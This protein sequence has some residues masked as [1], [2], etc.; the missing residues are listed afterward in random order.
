MELARFATFHRIRFA[1]MTDAEMLDLMGRPQDALAWRIGTAGPVGPDGVRL[2]GNVWCGLALFP[3]IHSARAVFQSPGEFLPFV[4]DAAESWH[5]L[6]QPFMHRGECN[7]LDRN[8][9]G[10]FFD[11]S[12]GDPG[13]PCLVLTSAGFVAGPNLVME[14]VLSFRRAVD[15]AKEWMDAQPGILAAEVFTPYTR[16]EDGFTVSLWK[17]DESMLAAAYRPGHHRSEIDRHK[18]ECVMDRSSFTRSRVMDARG[19]WNGS[20][21]LQAWSS[22]S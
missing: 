22:A 11:A 8:N 20:D 2:P 19:R 13:G 9:P 15:R 10:L 6:I 5:A 1:G 3:D 14:R 21:P 18:S 12:F 16:G 4:D 17:D 7:I